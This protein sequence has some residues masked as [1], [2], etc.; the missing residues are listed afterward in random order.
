MRYSKF[1]LPTQ[2]ETPSDADTVAMSYMYRAGMVR[3]VSAGMFHYLPYFNMI[4]RKVDY[5]IRRGMESADCNEVKFPLLVDRSIMETSGRWNAFGKEMFHLTDRNGVDYTVSPTNEEYATLVADLFVKSY[6]DLPFSIFQIQRKYRD[7][8]RPRNGV[9]RSREFTMK[10][11]YSFHANDKDLME[12]YNKMANVYTNIYKKL[13]LK[14]V[15]VVADSGAMGGKIC[16]E[17]MAVSSE[18][19]AEIAFCDECGYS[20]NLETVE[21]LDNKKI[22][23]TYRGKCEE[24]ITPR[25]STIDELVRFLHCEAKDFVK[26]MV[27]NADGKLYMILVRGD[28]QVNESKLAKL[29]KSTS[30]ELATEKEIKSIG[31]VLGFVGPLGNLKNVTIIADYEIKGMRDFVVGANKKDTHL[32]GVDA[33]DL[34]CNW[35]D[36]RFADHNDCCPKCG[37]KLNISMGNELGHI[38][39]LGKRYTERFNTTYVDANGENQLLTMGCYGIGL[40]RTVASIIDQHHDEKG[41]ILPMNVAPFKVDLIVVD[42]KKPE[43]TQVAEKLY[44]ELE[45]AGIPV[46]Y[47]D[48]ECRAG[49]KFN[50]FELIGVPIRVT[51]GRKAAE[52]FAEIDIRA[53]GEK[54]EVKLADIKKVVNNII[55]SQMR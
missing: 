32:R 43:Q 44:A 18:G 31:S 6:N 35:A 19:E 33:C 16:H 1:L 48:R 20:A 2:K 41:I 14:V 7:E 11:A 22:D 27:Y 37:G 53:T 47:D 42:V 29:L 50:D 24:I 51:I 40:E 54:L 26:S 23:T 52:G 10:D 15:P 45:N 46:L 49:V 28:R 9:V 39:A 55:A 25:S 36:L 4:M 21:C 38:F 34:K 13:G 30:L 17:Y 12:Y 3:K 5:V 8:I